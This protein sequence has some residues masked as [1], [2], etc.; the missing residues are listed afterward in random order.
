MRETKPF[1][2]SDDAANEAARFSSGSCLNSIYAPN[3]NS[4]G[5]IQVSCFVRGR[6][7]RELLLQ[8]L[9]GN[10]LVA[11]A[12]HTAANRTWLSKRKRTV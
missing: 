12:L 4:P 3:E 8:V 7:Y 9:F 1:Q 2:H 6:V 11:P 10:E 5:D